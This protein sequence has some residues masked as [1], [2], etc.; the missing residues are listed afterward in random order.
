M[1]ISNPILP[2]CKGYVERVD[3]LGNHYYAPT[4]ETLEKQAAEAETMALQ[5]DQDALMVDHEYRL[6][7][8]ELGVI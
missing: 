3:D 7:L 2:A 1:S 5:N 6:A 8:L 4:Q